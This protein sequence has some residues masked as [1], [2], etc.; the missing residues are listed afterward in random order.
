ML[1][2]A[3]SSSNEVAE[4]LGES[5]RRV[6][7]DEQRD[8]HGNRGRDDQRDDRLDPFRSRHQGLGRGMVEHTTLIGG[9]SDA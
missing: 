3:A 6:G 8:G 4:A 5:A 1:G 7:G 9:R 2:T